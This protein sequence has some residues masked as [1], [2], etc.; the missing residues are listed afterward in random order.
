[1]K[2]ARLLICLLCGVTF[3][4]LPLQAQN[5]A[6]DLD[7]LVNTPPRYDLRAWKEFY[8]KPQ[9]KR[10][11]FVQAINPF[12]WVFSGLLTG[13]QQVISPQMSATCIY[14]VSCSRF[15]RI[16]IKK[17]GIIKGIA[18]TADRLS[19]CTKSTHKNTPGV[20]FTTKGKIKDLMLIDE[21]PHKH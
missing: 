9:K 2:I 20:F 11:T 21:H 16:A 10:I 1:M 6:T 19:R 8:K 17:Y 7:L 15:S 13:Y 5:K 18:L 4:H 3:V 12:Y 14:E